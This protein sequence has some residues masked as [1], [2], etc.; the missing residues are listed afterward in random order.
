MSMVEDDASMRQNRW[1]LAGLK[2]FGAGVDVTQVTDLRTQ[3]RPSPLLPEVVATL[4]S[5]LTGGWLLTVD[6]AIREVSE[7]F[8]ALT[9]FTT[10]DLVGLEPPF[11]FWP[12]LGEGWEALH[13]ARSGSCEQIPLDLAHREGHRIPVL[14][15]TRP[16]LDPDGQRVGLVSVLTDL[17]ADQARTLQHEESRRL[18]DAAQEQASLGSWA[19]TAGPGGG[20]M[21][22]SRQIYVQ[23]GLDPSTPA[24][25][26][27]FARAVHPEDAD[28]YRSLVENALVHGEPFT[29]DHR[30]VR[31]CGEV[32]HVHG[33][34]QVHLDPSGRPSAIRGSVQ[35]ITD[36][37]LA[38]RLLQAS[39]EQFRLTLASS[40]IGL[41]LV[42]LQGRFTTVNDA[43]CRIVGRSAAELHALS[44]AA[45][46]H[47]DDLGE[48]VALLTRLRD[49]EIESYQVEKRYRHSDG[50]WVW[51]SLHAATVRDAGGNPL[52]YVAQI[53]DIDEQRRTADRLRDQAL[54]D[55]LTG[56]ANRRA[57]EAALR[58]H[59]DAVHAGERTLAVAILDL[60]YF[61]VFNDTHGHPVG[62][63]LLTDTAQDWIGYLRNT[64]PGA[65]LA[66]IG[67]EEF[68]LALPGADV[69]QARTVVRGMLALIGQGQTVSAG[70][71]LAVAHDE[72]GMLMTRADA[73]LYAAKHQG[74]NRCE[75]L[76]PG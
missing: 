46:T 7:R 71:T 48:D 39:Q 14:F 26:D 37:V 51:T 55:P 35:D 60:D 76:L 4:H 33:T 34:A 23:L 20:S 3:T 6:G 43:L 67:G 66:R 75:V 28:H 16:L 5:V 52:H 58:N 36:R 38:E 17:D 27:V 45:V 59:L 56:L 62:D 32:R 49:G 1:A 12:S 61:K 44:I 29:Q 68:A 65:T 19:W 50:R 70:L 74:R 11:P 72:P 31:P 13:R 9:G 63:Q 64:L 24:D 42:D 22:W 57:W 54:T 47:P 41:A 30:I 21:V 15:T 2:G 10:K 8:C 73:A 25:Y 53:V 69:D 18:L 40:P